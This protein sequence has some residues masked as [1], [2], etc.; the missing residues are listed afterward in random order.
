[1][2][3]EIE[4]P[5]KRKIVSARGT[6]DPLFEYVGGVEGPGIRVIVPEVKCPGRR[7][8]KGAEVASIRV[9]IAGASGA[10]LTYGGGQDD[11]AGVQHPTELL[12]RLDTT[13]PARASANV[14]PI[15]QDGL[16][17][18]RF[19]DAQGVPQ[20]GAAH[21][22]DAGSLRLAPSAVGTGSG[23]STAQRETR[24]ALPRRPGTR[25]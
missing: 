22:S 8:R 7:Y 18:R 12:E 6:P 3:K 17:H 14:L 20:A 9:I 16:E 21:V 23:T 10:S 2:L 25:H 15:V 19:L 1:M 11:A 4:D 5:Y 24:G 13:K